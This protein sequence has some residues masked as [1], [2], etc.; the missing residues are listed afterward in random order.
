MNR[1]RERLALAEKTENATTAGEALKLAQDASGAFGKLLEEVNKLARDE[2]AQ[3]FQQVV[4]AATEQFSFVA[5]S[6][7]TLERLV[8]EKPGMMQPAMASEH[9]EIQKAH[10]TLVR[11]FDNSR[12]TESIT[13][14]EEAMR[15]AVDA[16]TRIDALIKMFGPAT[17]RDRGVHAALE[18]G[19]RL[20]FAGEVPAGPEFARPA[21]DC[22]RCD[23]A[24]ARSPVPRCGALRTLRSVGRKEPDSSDRRAHG[25]STLQSDR[26][27]LPAKPAGVQPTVPQ[28]LPERRG[29]WRPG[30]RDGAVAIEEVRARR[31]TL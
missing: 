26:P 23:V 13:G 29:V 14:V 15:L 28:L 7:A 3:R 5:N 19:A 31:R 24:G 2:F 20:Y 11:R 9:Q 4:A 1:A 12:R 10:S 21:R 6:F 8:A 16:R 25:R 22:Q 30:G 18:E 17:L 27:D